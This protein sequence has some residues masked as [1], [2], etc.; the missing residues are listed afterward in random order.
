MNHI[1]VGHGEYRF[2][3]GLGEC[4]QALTE[5]TALGLQGFHHRAGTSLSRECLAMLQLCR[6][7]GGSHGGRGER[8]P[9][10]G[11]DKGGDCCGRIHSSLQSWGR[12]GQSIFPAHR[13][14]SFLRPRRVI[15]RIVQSSGGRSGFEGAWQCLV[16]YFIAVLTPAD[17]RRTAHRPSRR[18][19]RAATH[20]IAIGLQVLRSRRL[21]EAS[22]LQTR[23]ALLLLLLHFTSSVF[24]HGHPRQHHGPHAHGVLGGVL[25]ASPGARVG[26]Q[27][28]E[29]E[30]AIHVARMHTQLHVAGT[31]AM[32]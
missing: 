4:S 20:P 22:A 10:T 27:A 29:S 12:D 19:L 15:P 30:D 17:L 25:A 11:A 32:P 5:P 2:D 23:V 18:H 28:I 7:T 14:T 21:R 16:L 3:E 31:Q 13:I 6:N 26:W 8:G 24:R 1:R 9:L